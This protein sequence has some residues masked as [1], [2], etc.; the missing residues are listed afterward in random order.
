MS[1]W[2]PIHEIAPNMFEEQGYEV[3]MV[4]G[5]GKTHR[6]PKVFGELSGAMKEWNGTYGSRE[7]WIK[8]S[9]MSGV[10]EVVILMD[11]SNRDGLIRPVVLRQEHLVAL[12]P[13]ELGKVLISSFALVQLGAG[14]FRNK[15]TMLVDFD[16]TINERDEIA[17]LG[18]D[19]NKAAA[20]VGVEVM[21]ED[22]LR[23]L[24]KVS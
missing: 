17:R 8:Y 18:I 14:F 2:G 12:R 16:G 7:E 9:L 24:L 15:P 21:G 5:F 4:D 13:T 19:V 1:V 23:K 3:F 11:A 6:N 20:Y 10:K 22:R